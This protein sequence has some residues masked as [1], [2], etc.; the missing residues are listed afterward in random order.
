[1]IGASALDEDGA[2][3]DFDIRE[4]SVARAIISN[5]R[6]TILVA[7]AGKFGRTAPVRICSIS[8]VWAFVTDT[9]PP[10]RFGEI[11]AA[12]GVELIVTEADFEAAEK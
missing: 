9:A 10:A 4:V 6:R 2:V 8:D 3:L 1:M 5:A 7:D 11:C 12:A